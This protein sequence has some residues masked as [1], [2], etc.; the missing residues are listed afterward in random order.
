MM[1]L[2][3]LLAGASM[4]AAASDAA[5]LA[6]DGY[7]SYLPWVPNGVVYSD[8]VQVYGE[9]V[10]QNLEAF[11][12]EVEIFVGTNQSGSGASAGWNLADTVELAANASSVLSADSLGI[13]D[14]DGASVRMRGRFLESPVDLEE[15]MQ[16][17]TEEIEDWLI[18]EMSD[19]IPARITGLVKNVS[20]APGSDALTD[21]QHWTVDGYSGLTPGQITSADDTWV[22]PIAQTNNGWR[23]ILRVA[24]FGAMTDSIDGATDVKLTFHG[25]SEQGFAGESWRLSKRIDAGEVATV[26]L[27]D[28]VPDDFV[29]SVFIESSAA[30]GAVAERMK[31]GDRMLLTNV[32]RPKSIDGNLQYAPLIFRDYN[33]WNT[34]ISV[35][36]TDPDNWNVVTVTYYNPSR[37]RVGQDT[38]TIPPQGM[39]FIY[40]PGSE[41]DE[42]IAQGFVGSAR[43]TGTAPFHAA[44]DQVKY[45]GNNSSVGQGMSYVLEHDIAH[46]RQSEFADVAQEGFGFGD[47][48]AL[49][50]LQKGDSSGSGDTSGVQLFNTS[51]TNDVKLEVMLYTGDGDPSAP[52]VNEV[53]PNPILIT[54]GPSQS[55]TLYTH[56]LTDMPDGFQGSASFEVVSGGGGVVGISNN[57]NYDVVGDG[58]A[59]Y[60]MVAVVPL[61]LLLED[62]LCEHL[63]EH[64]ATD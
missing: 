59:S 21:G 55:F 51:L 49:P 64:C 4:P 57:V 50:L 22:L 37:S 23:T 42:R 35:A 7:G 26:D 8:T 41:D 20:P 3:G 6:E 14:G 25:S 45:I 30:I 47:I 60:N 16:S 17:D 24:S 36:N 46:Y 15:L 27:S 63:P 1:L 58:S 38:L 32:S 34:G 12:V 18:E 53:D 43:I 13:P 33:Q 54:L 56:G 28:Y 52:T 39:E 19:A 40:S 2:A 44:V 61:Y 5:S 9:V 29:G 11:P 48:L 31:S 10:V 62:I